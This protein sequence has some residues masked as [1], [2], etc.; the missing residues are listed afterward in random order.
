MYQVSVLKNT[1]VANYPNGKLWYNT[2]IIIITGYYNI[3]VK[4]FF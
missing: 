4:K 2:V 1:L 3:V